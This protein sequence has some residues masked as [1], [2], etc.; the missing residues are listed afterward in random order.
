MVKAILDGRKCQTRRIV[1]YPLKCKTHYISIGQSKNAPPVSFS[2]FEVGQ[3]LWVRE[4]FRAIEQDYG[5]PRYE[6]KATETIN[7]RDKWKPSLFMPYDA[8]RLF[9]K[10]TNVRVEKL[11]DITEMDAQK[12]GATSFF[13]QYVND[14]WGQGYQSYFEGFKNI[15]LNINGEKSWNENP[16]Y[17][18]LNLNAVSNHSHQRTEIAEGGIFGIRPLGSKIDEVK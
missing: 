8:C 9:L 12:E 3:I 16:L 11:N 2:P 10:V 13:C 18:L 5:K 6:Y 14:A 4:T 15:W 7:L 1:K 17:G